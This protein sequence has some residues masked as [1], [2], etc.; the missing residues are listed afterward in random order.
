MN[1]DKDTNE[2]HGYAVS[3]LVDGKEVFFEHKGISYGRG[4]A[5]TITPDQR[6]AWSLASPVET[7]IGGKAKREYRRKKRVSGT[8][9]FELLNTSA[10][11]AKLQTILVAR[12]L[13][14]L[15]TDAI[16]A[17]CQVEPDGL[18][19]RHETSIFP[20]EDRNLMVLVL[21]NTYDVVKEGLRHP[22]LKDEIN[23]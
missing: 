13:S 5:W 19:R 11:L 1:T 12:D 15:P 10:F 22:D 6:R 21:S 4:R 9:E 17:R 20:Y 16:V 8:E 3:K 18:D 23:E 7:R 2:E 14:G